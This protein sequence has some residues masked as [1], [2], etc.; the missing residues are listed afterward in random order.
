MKKFWTAVAFFVMFTG[1][2]VAYG[3]FALIMSGMGG[4]YDKYDGTWIETALRWSFPIAEIYWLVAGILIL[5]FFLRGRAKKALSGRSKVALVCAGLLYFLV[6]YLLILL[7]TL[8]S[9]IEKLD[10]DLNWIWQV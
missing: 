3:E 10:R 8:D 4:M 9:A 7:P 1:P 2:V 6:F 5:H